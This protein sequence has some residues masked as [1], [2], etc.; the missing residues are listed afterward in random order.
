MIRTG[1]Y[2]LLVREERL[3]EANALAREAGFPADPTGRAGVAG[4]L[5]AARAGHLDSGETAA[6]LFT[7]R[8]WGSASVE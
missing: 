7:G 8:R 1:G 5:D 3:R 2:R 6:V 4:C